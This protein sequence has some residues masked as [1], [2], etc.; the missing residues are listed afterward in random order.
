MDQVLGP[1]WLGEIYATSSKER[2][3][4]RFPRGTGRE[5]S[6]RVTKALGQ[7]IVLVISPHHDLVLRTLFGDKDDEDSSE[8]IQAAHKV[9]GLARSEAIATAV[10]TLTAKNVKSAPELPETSGS[11]FQSS[12]RDKS[13]AK[14]ADTPKS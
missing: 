12:K 13:T 7:R 8:L 3:V 5:N 6:V 2:F 9:A 11:I 4:V 10:E 1:F 14:N